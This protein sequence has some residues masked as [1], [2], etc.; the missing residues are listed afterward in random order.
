MSA[1]IP[2]TGAAGNAAAVAAGGVPSNGDRIARLQKATTDL[3]GVFVEQ[4]FKAMR[5]TVPRD[6]LTEGGSGEEMFT[7]LLDQKIASVAPSR[8]QHGLS[9]AL[10]RQLRGRVD[11]SPGAVAVG[12]GGQPATPPAAPSSPAAI[13]PILSSNTLSDASRPEP[14]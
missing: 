1:I 9:D 11:S 4:L 10:L 14:S 3:E 2:P 5:E 8:W 13:A 12:G 7:A 6:G